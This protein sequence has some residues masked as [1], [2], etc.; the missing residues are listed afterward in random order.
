MT[1]SKVSTK[2]AI[3]IVYTSELEGLFK[4]AVRSSRRKVS[5]SVSP[6][7]FIPRALEAKKVNMSR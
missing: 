3:S 2:R 5:S 1:R 6:G 7:W 4:A